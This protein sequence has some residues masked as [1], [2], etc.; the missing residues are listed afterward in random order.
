MKKNIRWLPIAISL[1][2]IDRTAAQAPNVLEEAGR[3]F[4][5]GNYI[6]AIQLFETA[7]SNSADCKIPFYIGLSRYR[8]QQ[9]DE[10]IVDLATAANCNPQSVEFNSALAEAY[11]QKG[12]DNRA[13]AAFGAVIKLDPR[14]IPALRA[15]S[16]LYLRHDMSDEA[17]AALQTLVA[18]D[19]T[20]AR[21]TAD[22]AAAYAAHGQLAEAQ[23]LFEQ[24]IVLDPR[25]VSALAGLGNLDFKNDRCSPAVDILSRA[26]RLDPRAYEPLVLR[27]RCYTRLEKYRFALADFQHA[28]KIAPDEPEIHYYL[29]QTYRA[30]GRANQAEQSLTEFKRVRDRSAQKVELQ[31]DAARLTMD[32]KRRVEAG[33]LP[34]AVVLMERARDLDRASAPVRFRLAGLY[35]E[36]HQFDKAEASIRDAIEIAPSQWDY[37]FLQGLIEKGEDQFDLAR[38]SLERAVHLNPNAAEAHNQLGELAMRRNDFV[39]AVREFTRAAQLAP[40]EGSYRS[41]LEDANRR[42]RA[43]SEKKGASPER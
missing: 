8:L 12:D 22:L 30:M 38:Q 31:R 14:N 37:H 32:A 19:K 13:L 15:A 3:A 9:L 29:A 33:D 24:A 35:F 21:A 26:I 27:A 28:L 34:G 1:V 42:S 40:A 7:R 4:D 36:N 41:N 5:R 2:L 20:D 18:L 39:A 43:E 17:L 16:T 11:V 10:A 6:R 25:N 23:N